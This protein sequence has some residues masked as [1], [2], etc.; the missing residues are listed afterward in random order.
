LCNLTEIQSCSIVRGMDHNERA[1]IQIDRHIWQQM[2]RRAVGTGETLNEIVIEAW[3]A[4]KRQA[5]IE[6]AKRKKSRS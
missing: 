2:K 6:R 5:K 3:R 1:T 4:L